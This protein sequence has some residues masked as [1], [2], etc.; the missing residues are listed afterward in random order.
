MLLLSSGTRHPALGT[1][2][3]AAAAPALHEMEVLG[4][5]TDTQSGTPLIFLRSKAD[6]R[7]LSMAVGR[8]EAQSII[9]PLQGT[10]PPR[11]QTHDLMLDALHRLEARL[12]R[13]VIT[14][15][16]DNTY[17]AELVL[18]TPGGDLVIDARPSDA[19]ALALREEAP[20]LASDRALAAA[21]R[22]GEAPAP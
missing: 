5:A 7:Q 22:A 8:A 14:D 10:K 20:I 3:G 11:P 19:I 13:V 2:A 12:M 18:Q 6:K 9:L 17:F 15:L 1:A 21:R 16:R 4:V